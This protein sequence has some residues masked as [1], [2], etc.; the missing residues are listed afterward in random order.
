[1][2]ALR[3]LCVLAGSEAATSLAS[4]VRHFPHL[5]SLTLRLEPSSQLDLLDCAELGRLPHLESITAFGWGRVELGPQVLLPAL[6][7]IHVEDLCSLE[8]SGPLPSL[9]SLELD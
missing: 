9:Q 1:M 3:D 8:V 2:Q 7:S 4:S 5:A 6:A